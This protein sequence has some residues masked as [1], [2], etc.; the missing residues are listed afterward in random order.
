M[1]MTE[2]TSLPGKV[3]AA[4]IP[5]A[6]G[7]S[8]ASS[9]SFQLALGLVSL[10]A[11]AF[12][13]NSF[14]YPYYEADEGT[15][16]SQAWSYAASG[17]LSPYYFI[18]DHVPAGWIM[19]A[20]WSYLVGGF[21]T[22]GTSVNT[23][24]VF[25]GLL[26]IGSTLLVFAITLRLTKSRLGASAA[27]LFYALSPLGL[28]FHRRVLLD[29]IMIFWVLLAVLFLVIALERRRYIPAFLTGLMLG[30]AITVK[31]PAA[32]FYPVAALAL[33]AGVLPRRKGLGMAAVM[34]LSMLLPAV[35]YVI[36]A[37]QRNEVFP[38]GGVSLLG[39]ITWQMGRGSEGGA[40]GAAFLNELSGWLFRD[41]LT[42]YLGAASIVLLGMF[43]AVRRIKRQ[44]ALP[45]LFALAYVLFLYFWS[46]PFEFY[47]IPLLAFLV[48]A[49]GVFVGAVA[50]TVQEI[51]PA[52][53]R[54]VNV[55][56][57]AALIVPAFFLLS[58]SQVAYSADQSGVQRQATEWIRAN[59]PASAFV[60]ID[61]YAW[62]DSMTPILAEPY[63]ELITTGR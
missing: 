21:D 30:L 63:P 38:N 36:Y 29:N 18:Y 33:A 28:Y 54:N 55:V 12:F 23:G 31:E 51:A 62:V 39:G 41:P 47:V 35:P 50:Q 48:M 44:A 34:S 52:L 43:L 5:A 32:V 1:R 60:V 13:V 40:S 19:I 45:A 20:I 7:R 26:N 14:N 16:L 9:R 59:L 2:N 53:R 46:N 8:L 11:V 3:Q 24:R 22:F 57:G 27:A 10:A 6:R 61:G 49:I 17:Q 15:Y 37:W 4:S 25:M 42:L 58:G 56:L